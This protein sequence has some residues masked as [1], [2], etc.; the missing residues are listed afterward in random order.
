MRKKRTSNQQLDCSPL[1]AHRLGCA[2]VMCCNY[3]VIRF[4]FS[5][6]RSFSISQKFVRNL[7]E[8]KQCTFTEL[9]VMTLYDE[10]FTSKLH[11]FVGMNL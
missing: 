10:T 6:N 8:K 1:S 9:T 4:S 7:R 5:E 11:K 2:V 3:C